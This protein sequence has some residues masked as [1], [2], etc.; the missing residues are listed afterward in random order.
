MPST[1]IADAI[2]R[3]VMSNASNTSISQ[4]NNID[5]ERKVHGYLL[6]FVQVSSG[7]VHGFIKAVTERLYEENIHV[8][9]LKMSDLLKSWNLTKPFFLSKKSRDPPSSVSQ[10]DG[11]H[12]QR[13]RNRRHLAIPITQ[14]VMPSDDTRDPSIWSSTNEDR[15]LLDLTFAEFDI[16]A[17]TTNSFLHLGSSR[18]RINLTRLLFVDLFSSLAR[19]VA[20]N[21]RDGIIMTLKK[22]ILVPIIIFADSPSNSAKNMEAN[23]NLMLA[24][25]W[26]KFNVQSLLLRKPHYDTTSS[27][28]VASNE[29]KA[30]NLLEKGYISKSYKALFSKPMAVISSDNG[31]LQTLENLHPKEYSPAQLSVGDYPDDLASQEF[32][33]RITADASRRSWPLHDARPIDLAGLD[34]MDLEDSDSIL[35]KPSHVLDYLSIPRRN[36]APG[37]VVN[38][39][40]DVITLVI[41][42]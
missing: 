7:K 27:P 18:D 38:D 13:K 8:S 14:D 39:I 6:E 30:A 36:R 24:N 1:A 34:L 29:T 35:I 19:E 9:K 32:S 10:V 28:T 31:S 12:P 20:L 5:L 33:D 17:S 2:H 3:D 41:R 25:D 16:F 42:E 23:L 37:P 40:V 15:N 22:I 11:V 26:S 4:M 21:N